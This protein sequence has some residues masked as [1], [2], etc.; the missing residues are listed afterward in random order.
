MRTP[1]VRVNFNAVNSLLG[2]ICLTSR[3]NL[4][5]KGEFSLAQEG[6]KIYDSLTRFKKEVS[7]FSQWVLPFSKKRVHRVS[8]L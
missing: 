1:R 5:S 8:G 6:I 4:L 3:I 7:A 2:R